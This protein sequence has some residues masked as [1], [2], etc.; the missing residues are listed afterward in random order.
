MSLRDM[1]LR[2]SVRAFIGM[3]DELNG[4]RLSNRIG[5]AFW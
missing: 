5:S 2:E 3:N 4:K 1:S